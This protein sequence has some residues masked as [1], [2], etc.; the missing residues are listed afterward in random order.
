MLTA[1]GDVSD[2]VL[3]SIIRHH[4]AYAGNNLICRDP[5]RTP[6]KDATAVQDITL[7]TVF[8]LINN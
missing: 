5:R 3:Y 4:T 8:T 1:S 7:I 2:D 6:P